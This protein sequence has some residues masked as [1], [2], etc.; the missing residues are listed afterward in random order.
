MTDNV[1][2]S[3]MVRKKSGRKVRSGV[4]SSDKM[5]KTIT[6]VVKRKKLHP[7]Y[8]KIVA[9]SNKFKAHDEKNEA[10]EGDSVEITET[11]PISKDKCWRLLKIVDRK[12]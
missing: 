5:D 11:R 9:F 2:T 6:V 3:K 12:K 7:L 4:V 1:S 10:K 8:G